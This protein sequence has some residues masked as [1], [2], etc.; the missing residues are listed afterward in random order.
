MSEEG[1]VQVNRN[2]PGNIVAFTRFFNYD[3]LPPHLQPGS[4]VFKDLADQI[5]LDC[6]LLVGEPDWAEVMVGLRNLLQAKDCI[7][8]S[9]LPK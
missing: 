8:R 7:V 1:T 4:K 9:R 3:H 6:Q 5:L 2:I